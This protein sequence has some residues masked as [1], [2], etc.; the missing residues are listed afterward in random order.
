MVADSPYAGL[1][2]FSE[3]QAPYFFGRDA[4]REVVTAN[5]MAS[6]LTLFYGPSGVGKSSV[7]NAGVAYHLRE[8]ARAD[9][10]SGRQP[11]S[12]IVLFRSW[13]DEP[14]AAVERA[15]EQEVGAP[16]SGTTFGDRLQSWAAHI[17][18]ELL[19]VFDQFEEYFLYHPGESGEESFA[20]QFSRAVNRRDLRA[21]F[22]IS[23]REDSIAKLDFFKGRIP[24]LFDN[25]LRIDRLDREKG[26]DAIVRPIE[27]YNRLVAAP[28]EAVSI[29]EALVDAV[30]DQVR[31]SGL[32]EE[33]AGLGGV[34]EA[35][36]FT[37]ETPHLQLVMTRLWQEERATGSTRLRLATLEGLGGAS[38]IVSRHVESALDALSPVER[39][40]AARVFQYLVTPA[41]T[42][43]ALGVE[44]LHANAGMT[45]ADL[46]ELLLKLS[47]GDSRILMSVAP[48]PDQPNRER[49]QIFHDVL[50][51]KVLDWRRRYVAAAEQ[52]AA[53]AVAEEQ[54]RRAEKEALAA[55]RLRRLLTVAVLLMVVA[56]GLAIVAWWQATEARAQRQSAERLRIVADK[57]AADAELANRSA[58]QRRLELLAATASRA[59]LE[60]EN[61]NLQL[62]KEAADA[63]LSGQVTQAARLE[64][65]AVAAAQRAATRRA[66]E[67]RLLDAARREQQA[68]DVALQRSE[69]AQRQLETLAAAAPTTTATTE[70]PSG[71]TASTSAPSTMGTEPPPSEKPPLVPVP[72]PTA[73]PTPKETGATPP[74]PPPSGAA[75]T[76]VGDYREV[77]RRAINA[78]N[79]KQWKDAAGLFQQSLQLRGTDTGERISITGFGNIEPYVPHYYLGLTLMNLGDCS[80]A[81]QNWELA[82]SDGAIQKTNLYRSLLDGRKTCTR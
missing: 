79:R 82:E 46:R 35:N 8:E 61:R 34:K 9:L 47:A 23:M 38:S 14:L 18:G 51:Q 31:A 73:A 53:E 81:L 56:T 45:P 63:R 41:G 16:A 12:A 19:I 50:A 43:I 26:H 39:E 48:A 5:L 4:E 71:A 17:G 30:L 15:I 62:A 21:S 70:L 22:L 80:G 13:R 60:E 6:T 77:Y 24:N 37:I 1:M 25:Y 74:A 59:A 28:G 40:A 27:Q 52:R 42:K 36:D 11:Q 78:K 29:E 66:D 64:Q 33:G 7:I 58:E 2:P 49:F 69:S 54:R 67:A 75:S 65:D 32:R 72:P 44:D 3:E 57:G 55:S 10:A 20:V 76:S 68:G